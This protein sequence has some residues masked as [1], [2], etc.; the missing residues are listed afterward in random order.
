LWNGEDLSI[1]SLDDQAVPPGPFPPAASRASLD[2][3]S[4]TFSKAHATDT[5]SI[6][7]SNIQKTVSSEQMSPKKDEGDVRGL[8]AAEAFIRP[9]PVV[10]H[11]D[12]SSYGF[13]LRYCT[14]K[15]ALS[16]PSPTS[17][18]APT[19]CYLPEFHF[20]SGQTS[21]E[22]SGGKWTIT[23]EETNGALQQ[24]L[25]WWHAAGDQSITVK[26]MVRKPGNALGTEDDE[27]GYL[28]QYSNQ[29]CAVM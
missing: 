29:I 17:E 11:G 14:F 24:T 18:D 19:V 8:R 10:V 21:V 16:A 15:L 3:S 13:D 7:P 22:V 23:S 6:T 26:G 12:V 25:R 2:T 27:G 20:P 4:P 1:Y 5:A 28:Q 9:T